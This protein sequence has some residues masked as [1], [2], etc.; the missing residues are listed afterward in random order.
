MNEYKIIMVLFRVL[1][2]RVYLNSIMNSIKVLKVLFKSFYLNGYIL[3]R[4][5]DRVW[6]KMK[7]CAEIFG[8]IMSIMRKRC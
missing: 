3:G 7:N 4:L 6:I 1:K 8:N 5:F 2:V